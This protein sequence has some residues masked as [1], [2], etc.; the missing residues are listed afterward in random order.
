ME[1]ILGWRHADDVRPDDLVVKTERGRL[2]GSI[3]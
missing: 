2:L 3:F 1:G